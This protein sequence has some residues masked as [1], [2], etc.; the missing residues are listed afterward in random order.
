MSKVVVNT[1]DS[2]MSRTRCRAYSAALPLVCVQQL[3]CE[4][5]TSVSLCRQ[6]GSSYKLRLTSTINHQYLL[7]PSYDPIL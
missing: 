5:A 7:C 2:D 4:K 3:Q 1:Y 6:G